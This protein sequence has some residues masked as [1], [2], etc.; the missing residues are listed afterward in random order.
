MF[1]P[2]FSSWTG[3]RGL[4]LE[5][6]RRAEAARGHGVGRRLM[7]E[8]ARIAHG[9]RRHAHRPGRPGGNRARRFYAQLGLRQVHGWLL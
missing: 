5:D 3:R 2:T 1:Y 8:L 6:F 9:P 4:F 7:V